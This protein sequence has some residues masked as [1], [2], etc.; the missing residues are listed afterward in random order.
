MNNDRVAV[1]VATAAFIVV[2]A[3]VALSSGPSTADFVVDSTSPGNQL[4]TL[5]PAPPA[6]FAAPESRPGGAV[7]LTWTASPTETVRAETTYSVRRSPAGANTWTQVVA[8][9]TS[10]SYT[11][12]PASDGSYDYK[13][14]TDVASFFAESAERAGLSDRTAP[15]AASGVASSVNVSTTLGAVDLTWT[16]GS[17]ATSGLAGY[18]IRYVA[19]GALDLTCPAASEATYT[20]TTGVGAVTSTT[21]SGLS[22]ATMY[23][24]YLVTEDGAGNQSGASNVA[25]PTAAK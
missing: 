4:T 25:G 19:V 6:T 1:L 9:L 3:A 14:R 13:I 23:C 20:S 15:T 5:E 22:S 12:T 2:I 11:D 8:G 24:F 7:L 21:V 18:T 16:A 17:D 10:L